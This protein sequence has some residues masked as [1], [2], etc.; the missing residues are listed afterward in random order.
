MSELIFVIAGLASVDFIRTFAYDGRRKDKR[1]MILQPSRVG[2]Y[3]EM[4]SGFDR[5][6]GHRELVAH[7][8]DANQGIY[9]NIFE[10]GGDPNRSKWEMKR[11]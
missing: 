10:Y 1:K 7:K 9:N 3:P 4:S 2:L 11:K 8:Q 6:I 5:F